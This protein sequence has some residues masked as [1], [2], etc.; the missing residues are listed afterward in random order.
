MRALAGPDL[1]RVHA[2]LGSVDELLSQRRTVYRAAVRLSANS[3]VGDVDD[4]VLDNPVVR[5]HLGEVL[6]GSA[7]YDEGRLQS[8]DDLLAGECR[9]AVGH[10]VVRV[11]ST[12][13]ARTALSGAL[14][15]IDEQ[16]H[17][18]GD[19]GVQTE[20]LLVGDEDFH[21]AHR[22]LIDG[23]RLAACLSPEL[24][25][26]LTSHVAVFALLKRSSAARLGSASAREYPGLILLPA[27]WSA[28]EAAEALMHEGAHQKFFDLCINRAIFA[29]EV[30]PSFAPSWAPSGSPR[31]SFEQAFAA[32]HAYCCLAAF[33]V[34]VVEAKET[35]ELHEYSLLPEAWT[36]SSEVGAWLI[37]QSDF[38]GAEGRALLGRLMGNVDTRRASEES[39]CE[40][41]RIRS[42][43]RREELSC[44]E[45]TLVAEI[46][47]A[48][49]D[50]QPFILHWVRPASSPV[51]PPG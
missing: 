4:V 32:F 33:W 23:V 44:G 34:A 47:H 21:D 28:L 25:Q 22:K 42:H 11:A 8:L 38:L 3:F 6:A 51:G 20:L 24:T 41:P 15:R 31:W 29:T 36:R 35:P 48:T 17:R 13:E 14:R 49:S 50:A 5:S 10:G 9:S 2:S 19:L 45:W 37:S 39:V 7:S 43:V 12:R 16:L 30:G 26:D 27:P 1:V 46:A 40:V 18:H